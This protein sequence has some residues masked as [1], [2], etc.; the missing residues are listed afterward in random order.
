MADRYSRDYADVLSG[1][2]PLYKN[3]HFFIKLTCNTYEN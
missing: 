3:T 1:K 2:V